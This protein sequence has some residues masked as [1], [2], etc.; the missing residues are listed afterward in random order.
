MMIAHT[1][2]FDGLDSADDAGG[3]TLVLGVAVELTET[4]GDD[5]VCGWWVGGCIFLFV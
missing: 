4:L 5:K 2:V 1:A 3:T